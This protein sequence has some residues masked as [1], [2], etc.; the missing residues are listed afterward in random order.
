MRT[1]RKR[2]E[3]GAIKKAKEKDFEWK[4]KKNVWRVREKRQNEVSA[5]VKTLF[6]EGRGSTGKKKK[7]EKTKMGL[8]SQKTK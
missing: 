8:R 7:E 4:D 5:W 3:K 2:K 6:T 1:K